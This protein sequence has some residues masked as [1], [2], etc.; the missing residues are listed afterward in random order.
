[1]KIDK[2][3]YK[4]IVGERLKKFAESKYDKLT[5]FAEAIEI[6]I[7]SL[8]SIYFKGKSLL[9]AEKLFKLIQMGCDIAW[10]LNPDNIDT[11]LPEKANYSGKQQILLIKEF[12]ANYTRLEEENIKLKKM[13]KDIRNLG[14]KIFETSAPQKGTKVRRITPDEAEGDSAPEL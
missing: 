6:N 11:D 7:K 9:G 8:H 3:T 12:E 5:E 14:I 2:N 13:I 10:L 4:R 1:M